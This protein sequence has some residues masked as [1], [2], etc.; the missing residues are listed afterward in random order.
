MTNETKVASPVRNANIDLL[1]IICAFFVVANHTITDIYSVRLEADT[2]W[3]FSIIYFW[4]SKIAVPTFIIISGY[5]L[6][7]RVDP[8]KKSVKRVV[9]TITVIVIFSAFYYLVGVHDGEV[10][11]PGLLNFI[12]TIWQNSVTNAYW[13]LYM[14]LGLMIMLP[15]LQRLS[16]VMDRN[17]YLYF[18]V[19]YAIF[20]GGIPLLTNFF[21]ALTMQSNFDLPLIRTHLVLFMMGGFFKKC[22]VLSKKWSALGFVAATSV[23]VGLTYMLFR[24]YGGAGGYLILDNYQ[25]LPLV[26]EGFFLFQFVQNLHI[27]EKAGRV[28]SY[29]GPQTFGVYLIADLMIRKTKGN[30]F[31]YFMSFGMNPFV[32]TVLWD[33]CIFVICMIISILLRLIPP[34]KK[35]I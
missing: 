8:V 13:F 4:V 15:I 23:N 28:I 18:F 31:P 14:Y 17:L 6:L 3:W 35:L 20:E 24:Q 5:L 19:C 27:G 25:Y 29:L 34:M 7:N 30:I 9:R 11:D 1:R 10:T 26:L 22:G 12:R 33:I 16:T 21:P 2:T 32:A